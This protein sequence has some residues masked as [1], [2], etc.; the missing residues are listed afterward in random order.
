MVKKYNHH[1]N[2]FGKS[3]I[4]DIGERQILADY[5]AERHL[6]QVLKCNGLNLKSETILDYIL[7]HLK[8][9]TYRDK[10]K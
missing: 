8:E 9:E 4:S 7:D 1:A 10:P 2:L 6:K 5:T 3:K